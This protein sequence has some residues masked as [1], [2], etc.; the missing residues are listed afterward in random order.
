MKWIKIAAGVL[1]LVVVGAAGTA[2]AALH[3]TRDPVTTGRSWVPPGGAATPV[4][5]SPATVPAPSASVSPSSSRTT[6]TAA[7]NPYAA[8]AVIADITVDPGRDPVFARDA[9][10]RRTETYTYR[11]STVGDHRLAPGTFA[12]QYDV[13]TGALKARLA[14]RKANLAAATG[15]A[16]YLTG[17]TALGDA[18]LG[19]LQGVHRDLGLTNLSRLYVYNLRTLAGGTECTPSSGLACAGQ[20]AR[21]G[22]FP[23][24]WFNGWWDTWVKHLVLDDLIEVPDGAFSNHTFT[25]MS[26]RAAR[27][28]GVMAFGHGPRARLSVLYLPSVRAIAHDAFRRNQYLTKVNLPRV[29][30]IADFAFDD[31]SRLRYL[32]APQ[33]ERIG[34]NA[35]NDSHALVS[36]NLPNLRYMGINCFDLNQALTGLRLPAL[37][38]LD[39]NAIIRFDNLRWLY[40]PR[41]S[42]ARHD[43]ITSNPKL[44]AVHLPKITHLGPR[45]LAGN[46]ALARINLGD[47]PPRQDSDVFAGTDQATIYHTG[48]A[49]AWAGFV[50][51]GNPSLPIRARN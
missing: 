14:E 12:F 46:P 24:L 2:A 44:S 15:I 42:T 34:R 17:G 11:F 6:G 40:A 7:G 21:G 4:T 8:G 26:L 47:Q 38:E 1:V 49:A 9:D 13:T 5:S 28:I 43:S 25:D 51:A 33:L 20:T 41:L 32:N 45:A 10:L 27:S 39:K 22:T 31:A 36:V 50:P 16:L 48:T 18:D 3:G 30:T 19:A 23:Y 29:T 35:L 37:T